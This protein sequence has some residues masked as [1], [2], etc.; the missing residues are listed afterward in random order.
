MRAN[1]AGELEECDAS[2]GERASN[3]AGASNFATAF[4]T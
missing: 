2:G 3:R 1:A 4:A